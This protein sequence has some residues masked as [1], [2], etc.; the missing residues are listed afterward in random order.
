MVITLA[1]SV[2]TATASASESSGFMANNSEVIKVS[3][4]LYREDPDTS[5]RE[6][7]ALALKVLL[8]GGGGMCKKRDWLSKSVNDT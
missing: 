5:A 6:L 1:A 8:L 3:K 4:W 7:R 2:A